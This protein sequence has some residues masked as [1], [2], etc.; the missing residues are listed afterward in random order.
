MKNFK[1]FMMALHHLKAYPLEDVIAGRFGVHEQTARKWAKYYTEKIAALHSEKIVW[2]QDN[3]WTTTF[4][5]SVDGVNFGLNEPRHP[6]LHKQK[7]Y[8]DCKGGKA[9]VTYEVALHLWENRVVWFNG[10]FPANENN[11]AGIYQK[12]GLMDAVPEGKKVIGDKIYSGSPKC[13]THNSLDSEN[14]R[15][16]KR[17]AR[18]RQESYNARLKSFG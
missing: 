14:V 18:S 9:G 4:I 17:R 2:P 1:D 5:I 7:N 15:E 11:D 12:K 3:E 13:C 6:V 16:F 10:P 8:F